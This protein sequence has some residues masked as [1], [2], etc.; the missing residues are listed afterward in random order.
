MPS[1]N[2]AVEDA[3][4]SWAEYVLNPAGQPYSIPVAW[5]YGAGPRPA[6]PYIGLNIINSRHVGQG[7]QGG[8][9]LANPSDP[10]SLATQRVGWHEEAEVSIQG[11]GEPAADY[12]DALHDSLEVPWIVD[13][14]ESV[15][16]AQGD[17]T[18]RRAVPAILD[19]VAE[20][21]W[22]ME[23]I[24]RYPIQ[25]AL[26]GA[27]WIEFVQGGGTIYL[28]DGTPITIPQFTIGQ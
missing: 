9:F 28:P 11:H 13:Y 2:S 19:E 7:S 21:R 6:P 15:G 4:M 20:R 25:L 8:V 14:L 26:P 24:F 27:P 12:V 10:T 23:V 3:I 22:V 17:H 5:M 1:S 16:L 18:E